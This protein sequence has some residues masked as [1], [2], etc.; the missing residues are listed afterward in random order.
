[1]N[2]LD[3]EKLDNGLTIY[4]YKDDRRHSTLF[5]FVTLFGG[6]NKDFIY[7]NN[8]YHIQDGVAHILEHYIVECN[9]NGNFLKLLGEKQMSTNA[10][11]SIKMTNYYF[12]AVEDIEFGINTILKS[13]NNVSFTDEKLSTLKNPIYQEIRGKM[14]NKFYH[15]NIMT[16]DNLFNSIKFRSVG[17]T[18]EE[19]ENTTCKDLEICYK[20]FYHP[21]N[22]FIVIAGNFDKENILEIIRNNYKNIKFD[23]H[24][25]KKID[26]CEKLGVKKKKDILYFPTQ[27]D[28]VDINFKVDISN[29][30]PVEALNLDFYLSCFFNSQ[31]GVVS[32]IYKKLVDEKI[33]SGGISCGNS[34]IDKYMIISI[35]GYTYDADC[36]EKEI[37]E[38]VSNISELDRENFELDKK[39]SVVGMVLR[40]ESIFK[41]IG[42]F[43]ENVVS[44]DYPFLDTID[45]V[46]KTNYDDYVKYIKN[47]D[48]S[49]YTI[50]IIKDK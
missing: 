7:N 32:P 11:T 22:Q 24:E 17:G 28:Y 8:E 3:V 29:L 20:A 37:L 39:V 2:K 13:V 21:S 23:K 25:L 14:N 46:L 10:S 49:N 42:P 41:V 47:I 6:F 26:C 45:D 4:L 16:Y 35:S 48:F 12:E 31:F 19:I 40:D 43:I 34:I 15:S 33:I 1:M 38:T 44:Y 18:L 36:F 30:S 9:N 27:E 5:Q 50:T